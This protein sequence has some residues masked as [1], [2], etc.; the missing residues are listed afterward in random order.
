[1]PVCLCALDS[2][3]DLLLCSC[4]T[5]KHWTAFAVLLSSWQRVISNTVRHMVE[6]QRPGRI[7]PRIP[8][9]AEMDELTEQQL[10]DIK[11]EILSERFVFVW[12]VR[13]P[14]FQS[15]LHIGSLPAWQPKNPKQE[16]AGDNAG[17]S[18]S[19][20]VS[21]GVSIMLRCDKNN[22]TLFMTATN[23]VLLPQE[24]FSALKFGP[25]R[26]Y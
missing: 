23:R 4:N 17:W 18:A 19:L 8:R 14:G 20:T 21:C 11:N 16:V 6:V 25:I 15:D 10:A 2:S 9:Q 24:Y 1:M 26:E 7:P 3:P 22:R 12:S 5:V 13:T